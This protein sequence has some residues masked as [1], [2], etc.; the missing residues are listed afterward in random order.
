MCCMEQAIFGKIKGVPAFI[1]LRIIIRQ[2]HVCI[3]LR[4]HF[5][6][7]RCRRSI[8]VVKRDRSWR[9][10]A[11]FGAR[12]SRVNCTRWWCIRRGECIVTVVHIHFFIQMRPFQLLR[13]WLQVQIAGWRLHWHAIIF[14]VPSFG[15][16]H[17][18]HWSNPQKWLTL[19]RKI[20]VFQR[21]FVRKLSVSTSAAAVAWISKTEQRNQVIQIN[22][23]VKSIVSDCLIGNDCWYGVN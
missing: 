2:I 11:I 8:R 20:S 6:L 3:A 18:R 9:W 1:Q 10:M 13:Q 19:Q 15:K 22:R 14:I 4:Y 12:R 21:F 17:R 23:I 16:H 7:M 5:S